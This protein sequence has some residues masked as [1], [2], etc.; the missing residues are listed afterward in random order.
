MRI[1]IVGASGSGTTALGVA[2]AARL[3]SKHLDTDDYFWQPTQP[4]YQSPR[5][6]EERRAR[7]DQAARGDASWVLSG[8]LCGWGDGLIP[9]F[10][11]VV[12]LSIPMETRLARLRERELARFG[13]EALAPGGAMHAN[14]REF[15]AWAGSYDDGDLTMRSRARHEE[16][17]QR[18]PCPVLRCDREMVPSEQVAWILDSVSVED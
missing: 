2:L 9:R 10:R 8:S 13:A 3:G 1:H 11:W 17:L 12:F 5:P 7:L 4:P 15:L 6:L 18:L 14:H 16:W